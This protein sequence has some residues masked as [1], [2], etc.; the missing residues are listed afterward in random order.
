MTPMFN[1][2]AFLLLAGV[3]VLNP[4]PVLAFWSVHSGWTGAQL[5]QED[6]MAI[7]LHHTYQ[8]VRLIPINFNWFARSVI[9]Q[10]NAEKKRQRSDTVD[11]DTQQL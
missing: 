9:E 5:P 2:R 1:G 8:N 6:V 3:C 4:T 7:R 10:W 11:I